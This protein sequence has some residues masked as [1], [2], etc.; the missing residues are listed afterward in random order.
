MGS[1]TRPLPN[2]V[3]CDPTL[4]FN[5]EIGNMATAGLDILAHCIE[6]YLSATFN[7]PADGIALE[8][9]RR[10]AAHL[11]PAVAGADEL[12]PR[13]ELLAAALCAGL[14]AEKGLGAA[15]AIARALEPEIRPQVQHGR[16]HAAVLPHVL[17]YN[18]PAVGDRFRALHRVLGVPK[19]QD[20]PEA[21]GKLGDRLGLPVRLENAGLTEKALRRAARAAVAEHANRTNPRHATAQNYYDLISAAL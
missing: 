20:L 19:G 9:A 17:A 6:S 4:T 5:S 2:V 13:R 3:L 16:F 7:P 21:L 15:E 10:V 11:E 1:A 18:A 14:A 8:G 12:A